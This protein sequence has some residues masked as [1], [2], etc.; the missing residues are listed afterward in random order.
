MYKIL[1]KD[2]GQQRL[3]VRTSTGGLQWTASNVLSVQSQHHNCSQ[4]LVRIEQQ[5]AI[6]VFPGNAKGG[7]GL[8]VHSGVGASEPRA[9]MI[10][11]V[12][13]GGG[14]VV[15]QDGAIVH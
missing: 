7:E 12:A 4:Q 8:P 9:Q 1:V 14:E 5:G 11:I 3:V 2:N 10:M 13:T 15:Q 6:K